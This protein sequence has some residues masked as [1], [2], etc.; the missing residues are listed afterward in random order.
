MNDKVKA[1]TVGLFVLVG[2]LATWGIYRCVDESVSGGEGYTVWALF[3]DA[4]GLVPK[5]RVLIAGIS[6]GRIERIALATP[7]DLETY[8]KRYPR[9]LSVQPGTHS[10]ARIDIEI[11]G[12]LKIY[13]DAH[14]AKRFTS[15]LGEAILVVDPGRA[16]GS[17][18]RSGDPILFVEEG[19][20]TDAL[21]TGARE[22]LEKVSLIAD[23]VRA[24]SSQLERAF[25]TDVAG[26]RMESALKNLAQAL[27]VAN[28]TIA[29][30]EQVIAHTLQ[31][32]EHVTEAGGPKLIAVLDNMQSATQDIRRI[33]HNNS[34]SLERGVGEIPEAIASIHRASER[35]EV[36]LEDIHKTTDR[37][38]RGEGTV[39]RLTSDETLIDEVE[40]VAE[41]IGS[42]VGGIARL[43]TLIELRSEFNLYAN[44]F[45]SYVSLRIQPR[46]DR[47]YLI[48]LVNDPRGLTDFTQTTV[49]TS[50]PK[51]GDPELYQE[52]RIVTRDSFR[53]S[54][55][56]A[57]RIYFATFRFGILESTGGMGTD[58]HLFDDNLE[59][60]ADL[61]AIGERTYPRLRARLAYQVSKRS[62][63]SGG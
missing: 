49:R 31:N 35:L 33:L 21:M 29:Q 25:G 9:G 28:R 37:T 47:Y 40:G 14:I 16:P 63:F 36:V 60:T 51:A 11:Q 61:F 22:V 52:T 55:M 46:E 56:F 7:K 5:S 12:D 13:R 15:L 4:Q 26:Q 38:A 39:G 19:T 59:I 44:T 1:A 53:F 45:K 57:K 41:G 18:L 6:I 62:G 3:Q 10:Y 42:V 54:L 32:V 30:N 43:Q 24:V 20:S 34:E 50:P 2:F 48:Q 8:K 58:L 17:P 23:N 27:E